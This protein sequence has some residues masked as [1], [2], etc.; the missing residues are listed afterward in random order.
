MRERSLVELKCIRSCDDGFTIEFTSSNSTQI[1]LVLPYPDL[2]IPS[3]KF[4]KNLNWIWIWQSRY[5]EIIR[6]L[7]RTLGRHGEQ[8]VQV[9]K[10]QDSTMIVSQHLAISSHST[11]SCIHHKALLLATFDL[12]P[13]RNNESIP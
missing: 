3:D 13:P 8:M 5:P 12:R 10:E 6:R 2:T 11:G 7:E 1:Q 4:D 9:E